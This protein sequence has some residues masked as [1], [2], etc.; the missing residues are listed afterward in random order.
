[1][2]TR[3][4]KRENLLAVKHD[5]ARKLASS[6]A[7]EHARQVVQL[8]DRVR[9]RHVASSGQLQSFDRVLT[10]AHVRAD[11]AADPPAPP[12]RA[13]AGT[14]ERRRKRRRPKPPQ[15]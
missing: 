1:M 15:R 9:G 12:R 2:A 8:L 14:T 3:R 13:D 7:L 6:H 4:A 10:V 11:D 5:A